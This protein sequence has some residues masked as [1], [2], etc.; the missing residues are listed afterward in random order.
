MITRIINLLFYSGINIEIKFISK[1]WTLE[2]WFQ[3]IVRSRRRNAKNN[4]AK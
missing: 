2:D 3:N 1:G 4:K